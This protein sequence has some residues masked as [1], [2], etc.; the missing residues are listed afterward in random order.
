M[1]GL[2]NQDYPN[3]PPDF[4]CADTLYKI[5]DDRLGCICIHDL[6]I[7]LLHGTSTC[8]IIEKE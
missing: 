1:N 5:A 4:G 3:N 6:G 7:S 2:L 8:V